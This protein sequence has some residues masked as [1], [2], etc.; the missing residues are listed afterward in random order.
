[1]S[2]GAL[3]TADAIGCDSTDSLDEATSS[4]D[5]ILVP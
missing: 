5:L 4:L 1:M 3:G 2:D